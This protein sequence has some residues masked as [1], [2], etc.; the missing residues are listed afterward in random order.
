MTLHPLFVAGVAGAVV[1]TRLGH[2]S[3]R[4]TLDV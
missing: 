4:T 1:T 2:K 3:I